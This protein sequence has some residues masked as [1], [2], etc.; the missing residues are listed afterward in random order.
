MKI[1]HIAFL[2]SLFVISFNGLAQNEAKVSIE[3]IWLNY[4]FYPES[5][6][7]VNPL[8]DDKHYTILENGIFIEKYEYKTGK[9]IETL[10]RSGEILN[11]ISNKSI[12]KIDSYTFSPDESMLLIAFDE[13]SL[14]RRSS[15]A[16]Y[17]IYNLKTKK[18]VN[19][20][21][22][23]KIQLAQFSPDGKFAS[24]IYKNN[25]YIKELSSNKVIQITKDGKEGQIINGTTDWVYEEELELTKGY[26]WSTDGKKIAFMRFDESN[27]KEFSMQM[28]ESLYPE[29]HKF[30]Y[31]KAGEDNSV[32]DVFVYDIDGNKSSKLDVGSQNDQY[33]PRF[34]WIPNSNNL[35]VMKMNRHQNKMDLI[36]FDYPTLSQKPIYTEENKYWV[37]VPEI[38]FANNGKDIIFSS[39]SDGYN[40]IYMMEISSG[41]KK[42]LTKGSWQIEHIEGVDEISKKIYFTAYMESSIETVLAS[43]TPDGKIEK[44]STQKGKNSAV[45]SKKFGYFFNTFSNANTP[46]SVNLYENKGKLVREI[47]TN[48][49]L[50]EKLT[51]YKLSPKEFFTVK[52]STGN[53]LNAWMIKPTNFDPNKKY[54][55]LMYVYGGP[56]I[57][58]V[59]NEWDYFDYFW[60][61]V[62]ADKGYIVAC[63]DNRGTGG[64]G[65]EFKKCI[66]KQMGKYETE[67]Q[68]EGAKYFAGL[69]YVDGKRIG[70][71]GWSYGGYMST[72]CITK[73]AAQ[74]KTAIAVAPVTNWRY[75][76]NIYTERFMQTPQE[77]PKG[78]DDNSPI[79]HVSKLKGNFMLIHGSSDDNVHVQN[80]MMLINSLVKA[81]KQFEMFIYPNRNH[82]IAGGNTRYNLYIKMTDFIERKL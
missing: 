66:Y 56:G 78:Y 42:Q 46:P 81:G 36:Q 19:L 15:E 79:N 12:G 3:D 60:Y 17:I 70:I 37:E 47:V 35:I 31:P 1:K 9:K 13:T 16:S 59:E 55:V 28:W 71:W 23:G 33:I 21:D 18:A 27:V 34:Y 50:K 58:S 69:P 41:S 2:L 22:E 4:A 76:D 64:K 39:E 14:Y 44:I 8:N 82:N 7:S 11:P 32:V 45:F 75:Y 20:F 62:L 65:E 57:K 40:H 10:A 61:Q 53:E 30:K 25:L 24:F 80:S 74:F 49:A 38:F 51:K 73:G 77:N 63:V 72:L 67:D 29:E 48:S 54:P 6:E 68:I 43:V 5:A 26:E 52:T